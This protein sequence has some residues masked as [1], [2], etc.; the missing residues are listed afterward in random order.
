[1]H[2]MLLPT[3]TGARL[4]SSSLQ[5]SHYNLQPRFKKVQIII[6]VLCYEGEMILSGFDFTSAYVNPTG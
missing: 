2:G 5:K 4:R 6:D 1:M 3:E